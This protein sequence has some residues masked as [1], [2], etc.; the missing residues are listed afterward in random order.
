MRDGGQNDWIGS[1]P[2]FMPRVSHILDQMYEGG[3]TAV[4]DASK[5]FYQFRTHPDDRPFLG[6]LHPLTGELLEYLG[7]PMGSGSSPSYAT[8]YG[9]AFLRMLREQAP[10]M[11]GETGRANCWWEGL[12]DDKTYDP[13]LGYGCVQRLS[14]IHI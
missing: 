3:F 5:F 4:V 10:E 6:I 2:V 11:F 9:L 14:L 13:T 1:D 7:L 12:Q 8:Q